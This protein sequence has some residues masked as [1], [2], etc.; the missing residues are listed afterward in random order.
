MAPRPGRIRKPSPR[1]DIRAAGL[2]LLEQG[3]SNND[4]AARCGVTGRTVER[5]KAAISA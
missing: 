5:W 1:E 3:E 2:A 4:V